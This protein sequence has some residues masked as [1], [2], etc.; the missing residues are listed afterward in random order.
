MCV[1]GNKSHVACTSVLTINRMCVGGRGKHLRKGRK[2][3]GVWGEVS[4]EEETREAGE[5]G[6]GDA[7]SLQVT[8]IKLVCS[9]VLR[10]EKPCPSRQPEIR[11]LTEHLVG[12]KKR[13]VGFSTNPVLETNQLKEGSNSPS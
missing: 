13:Q 6:G 5:R 8:V 1:L 10:P 9:S 11:A 12:E 7:E 4:E 3:W 2:G